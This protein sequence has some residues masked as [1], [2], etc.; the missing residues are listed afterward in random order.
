M[1]PRIL[2]LPELLGGR[3]LIMYVREDLRNR[4]PG[5]LIQTSFRLPHHFYVSTY[6]PFE[7]SH[8]SILGS[9]LHT[10]LDLCKLALAN[11]EDELILRNF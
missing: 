6:C 11:H 9:P 10:V 3:N 8:D 5:Y 1:E 4:C 7:G 2:L